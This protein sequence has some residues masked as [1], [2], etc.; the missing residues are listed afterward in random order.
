M[1]FPCWKSL[2]RNKRRPATPSIA[3]TDRI[4]LSKHGCGFA[5]G[6]DPEDVV[7]SAYK[8]SFS[9]TVFITGRRR[10]ELDQAVTQIGRNV[11]GVLA[12]VSHLTDLDR[13]F[14]TVK[15]QQG[16]LDV[17]FANAGV[18]ALAPLGEITEEHFDHVF[19]I[20]VKGLLSLRCRRRC[21]SSRTA[22]RSS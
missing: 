19:Q 16:R 4:N 18:V 14:A 3:S 2:F 17:L 7:Q 8:A 5:T 10:G 1:I 11:T 13:L 22:G 20:N 6:I 9:A 12:D 15:Q 21:R